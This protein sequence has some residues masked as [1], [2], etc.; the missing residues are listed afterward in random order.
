MRKYLSVVILAV[1]LLAGT[2]A[3]SGDLP[4]AEGW[5]RP[6]D[7]GQ[8]SYD[9]RRMEYPQLVYGNYLLSLGC[10]SRGGV[11]ALTVYD[12]VARK[13]IQQT[14]LVKTDR[15]V[16]TFD[17]AAG[18][19]SVH[20]IWAED[21]EPKEVFHGVLDDNFQFKTDPSV[22]YT[23]FESI[24][25][26]F[27]ALGP[28]ANH[29]LWS[30]WT[31]QGIA[32]HASP[33]ADSLQQQLLEGVV[34]GSRV[35]GVKVEQDSGMIHLLWNETSRAQDYRNLHYSLLDSDLNVVNTT[36]LGNTS[37][38]EQP[39]G[40]MVLHD[41]VL[42]VVWT[43]HVRG[44]LAG[45][46]SVSMR[47]QAFADGEPLQEAQWLS[48]AMRPGTTPG[49]AVNDAG[50]LRVVWSQNVGRHLEIFFG[51]V[52]DGQLAS[53]QRLTFAT[54]AYVMPRVFVWQDHDHVLYEQIAGPYRRLL[55]VD[56]MEPQPPKLLDRI[57]LDSEN[58]IGSI[59]YRVGYV[60]TM[61][62]VY[63][64]MSTIP[65]I[66][67]TA[68]IFLLHKLVG[69]PKTRL[70][71]LLQMFFVCTLIFFQLSSLS[72]A[73]TLQAHL[74]E[75]PYQLAMFVLISAIVLFLFGK[76]GSGNKDEPFVY[77]GAAF[78][79]LYFWHFIGGITALPFVIS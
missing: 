78:V 42:H 73:L 31:R 53:T 20:V 48:P 54:Y 75:G 7:I 32:I 77:G 63:T 45:R 2:V 9:S 44:Y 14:V 51:T 62:G 17:M 68:I 58:I 36:L 38:Q 4:W 76:Y 23:T 1:L 27:L 66:I 8:T 25:N 3:A 72:T 18:A 71:F 52:S 41:G 39:S 15:N 74:M 22:I 29:V 28:T 67:V 21:G 59:L 5:S 46:A 50:E 37:L 34:E 13:V 49:L 55:L 6:Q 61:S 24:S 69:P 64:V 26:I 70:S 33:L 47:Y 56:T 57:G 40:S 16:L 19:D 35:H 30:E 79:W 11:V 65:V 43:Q 12:L 10:D 60:A